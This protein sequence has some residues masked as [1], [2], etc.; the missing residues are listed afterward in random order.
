MEKDLKVEIQN[1]I[2]ANKYG[3][4]LRGTIIKDYLWRTLKILNIE[5]KDLYE[6]THSFMGDGKIGIN[7]KGNGYAYDDYK[8]EGNI[9]VIG[10]DIS[11][12]GSIIITPKY[13]RI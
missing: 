2:R 3:L 1:L 12:V 9:S 6:G 7:E 10:D 13:S 8:I 5:K 4:R 11:I